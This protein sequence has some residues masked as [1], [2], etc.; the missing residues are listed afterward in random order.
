[1]RLYPIPIKH[2]PYE[3]SERDFPRAG[4]KMGGGQ[5]IQ[6]FMVET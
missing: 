6:L 1:M 4:Q 3:G 2:V 5:K